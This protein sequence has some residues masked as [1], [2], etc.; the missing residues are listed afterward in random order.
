MLNTIRRMTPLAQIVALNVTAFAGIVLAMA[1]AASAQSITPQS[2]PDCKAIVCT[3]DGAVAPVVKTTITPEATITEVCRPDSCTSSW[4][5]HGFDR[6]AIGHEP[7][8]FVIPEGD[9]K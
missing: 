6:D 4:V 9:R 1:W 3:V 5:P 2:Q 8:A 7:E